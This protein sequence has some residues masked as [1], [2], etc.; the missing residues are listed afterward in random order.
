MVTPLQLLVEVR[1]GTKVKRSLLFLVLDVQTG[2]VRD[3]EDGNGRT[4]LLLC[5]ASHDGL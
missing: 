1:I 2:T 4:A 5:A 3:K